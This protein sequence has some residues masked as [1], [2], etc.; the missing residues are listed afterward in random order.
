MNL[1]HIF[2][3]ELLVDD[4]NIF[5]VNFAE[6]NKT[7]EVLLKKDQKYIATRLSI[8]NVIR[9]YEE[10]KKKTVIFV[11]KIYMM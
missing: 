9:Y 6:N 5:S 11:K 1:S 3:K 7:E 10:G 4:D 2:Y 8:N